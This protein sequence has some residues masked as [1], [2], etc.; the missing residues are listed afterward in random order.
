MGIP[1]DNDYGSIAYDQT[2]KRPRGCGCT[3]GV[4]WK[5]PVEQ[6]AVALKLSWSTAPRH[7]HNVTDDDMTVTGKIAGRSERVPDYYTRLDK[8][9]QRQCVLGDTSLSVPPN[10]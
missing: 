5:I 10:P 2:Q 9:E 8:L 4:D 3:L 7:G 1:R 6:F